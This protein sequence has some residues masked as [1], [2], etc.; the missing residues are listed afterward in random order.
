MSKYMAPAKI[1]LVLEV[2]G[3][4]DDGYHEIRSLT[5]TVS[6]YDVL[7]F[8]PAEEISFECIEPRLQ[9][10]ENLVVKAAELLRQ[11]TGY[12][13][14]VSIKL[15]KR[16]PWGTGLGGGSSD[17]AA[18]LLA[19]NELWEVRLEISKLLPLAAKLGSDVPFFIYGGAALTEGKGERVTPLPPVSGWLVLLVPPLPKMPSKTERLYSLL[20]TRHYTRGFFVDKAVEALSRLG[21]VNPSLLYNVFDNVAF[22]AFPG[23]EGWWSQ[24]EEAGAR[25]IHLAGSGLTMFAPVENRA[26][27]EELCGRLRQQGLEAYAVSTC[28]IKYQNQRVK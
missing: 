4:R 19:L 24:F 13:K 15:E 1:N 20:D 12:Y 3:R 5:Q 21:Q 2:L 25:Y 7:T 27:A 8:E 17:A 16:I 11:V 28:W 26:Q 22:D 10:A 18:T 23:L 9:N 14:G 6:L